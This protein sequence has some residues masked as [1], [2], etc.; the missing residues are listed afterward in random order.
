MISMTALPKNNAI[1]NI[2]TFD[3]DGQIQLNLFAAN[4]KAQDCV[5]LK[6]KC[7]EVHFFF[8]LQ[9]EAVFR[10]SPK[11]AKT[12]NVN[13]SFLLYDPSRDVPI[14]ISADHDCR[15]IHISTT[16][17]HLHELFVSDAP[18]MAFL[19]SDNR[20]RKYY[21]ERSIPANLHA[22]LQQLFSSRLSAQAQ[23]LFI[24]GKLYEILACY[25]SHDDITDTE[26]CPF[27]KDEDSVKR[28]KKAKTILID[29]YTNPPSLSQLA[30]QVGLN[31]FKLKTGFKE[32]YGNTVFGFVLD[33]KLET[34]RGMLDS[35]QHKINEIAFHM[36]YSNPSHFISAFKKKY[37]ITPKQYTKQDS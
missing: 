23:R 20:E 4:G 5:L 12:L 31:E 6:A 37:G 26:S 35:Q 30:R 32:V 14:E 10:F 16:I 1:R 17:D 29:A 36:G 27:L 2:F 19:T 8:C 18:E 7:P 13:K 11:Y 33:Y 34:A 28:I 3:S 24:K 15:L 22:P 25:F 21:D 9:S